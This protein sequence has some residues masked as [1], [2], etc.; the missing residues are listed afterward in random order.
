MEKKFLECFKARYGLVL[1]RK[2][3]TDR[4]RFSVPRAKLQCSLPTLQAVACSVGLK[5]LWVGDVNYITEV[6][7]RD[8]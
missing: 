2:Q 1:R 7:E 3:S 5:Q 6:I 8:N 4:L